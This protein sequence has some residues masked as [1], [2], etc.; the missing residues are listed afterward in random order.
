MAETTA[1]FDLYNTQQTKQVQIVVV[2]DGVPGIFASGPVFRKI[3]YGDPISYGEGYTYGGLI[4][5]V[6]INGGDVRPW[7][8]LEGSTLNL[9]QK[10]EPEQGRGAVAMLT[11]AFID[12]DGYMTQLCS[13]G[14]IVDDILGKDVSVYIGYQE[15]SYPEDYFQVFRGK[16]SA[17]TNAPGITTLQLSDGNLARRQMIFFGAKTTL[18]API[19]SGD[20]TIP[21][22]SN[23]DFHKAILGPFGTY[24][25]AFKFYL[26]IEDEVIEYGPSASLPLATFGT[27]TFGGVSRG[28]RGSVAAAHSAGQDVNVA[29]ALEDHGLD[30]A[31][32]IMLSGWNGPWVE[33]VPVEGFRQ[34]F[35]PVLLDQSNAIIFPAFVDPVREYN[36]QAGDRIDI[37][38]GV[39]AQDGLTVVSFGDLFG[40]TNRIVYVDQPLVLENPTT[41]TLRFRSQYDVYPVSCGSKLKPPQVDI[42]RHLFLKQTFLGAGE[43][44]FRFYIDSESNGKSFIESQLYLP[45]ACYSLTRFGRLSVGLT[46]PPI[47]DERLT[48]LSWDNILNPQELRPIRSLNNRK[49][50][51]EI[52]WNFDKDD[53]GE[54]RSQVRTL[55]TESLSIIGIS[56]VLPINSDGGRTD[57]GI[58]PFIDRRNAFLLYRYKRGAVELQPK[59]NFEAAM[60]IEAGDVV[61]LRD[62][63]NLQISNLNTGTRDLGVQLFEV[64]ERSLDLRNGSASLKLVSGVGGA[65][66][67]RF[68]VISPSS[69]VG[70]G[71]TASEIIITDSYGVLYPGDEKRKWEDYIGEKVLVHDIDWAYQEETVLLGFD[72]GNPYR[73]LVAPPL[74]FT[75]IAGDVVDIIE[76]PTGNDPSEANVYKAIHCFLDPTVEVTAGVSNTEFD[77]DPADIAKFQVGQPVIVHESDWA[78]FSPE[79]QVQAVDTGL[80]RVTV[81]ADLGFTPVAGYL[82]DLIGFADGG[83]PYRWI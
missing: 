9:S 51:N 47:A 79:V 41:S 68:G 33:N 58:E 29:L 5:I 12:K 10:L 50:F 48:F 17:H 55:D 46:K 62:D 20:T 44:S 42:E 71:S 34:T 49:F 66:T 54:F 2:I 6:S 83:G 8:A 7:L 72:P 56:S 52:I 18:A 80:N 75:P 30:A 14:Q 35:D 22:V 65:A 32:K 82:V 77:V 74:S 81:D 36:L 15:L 63:G 23:T 16:V 61:A 70:V 25:P 19:L 28:A 1:K 67:D 24:D 57:L 78:V 73:M 27:N 3:R 53:A 13:P 31:L 45:L 21:V 38:G 60:Q 76:Y 64:T 43:N 40:T 11:L 69:A 59:V 4:P 37:V 39:N 26:L